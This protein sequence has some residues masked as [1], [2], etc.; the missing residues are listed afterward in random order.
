MISFNKIRDKIRD[1]IS[2]LKARLSKFTL[3]LLLA[4]SFTASST[5]TGSTIFNGLWKI[6][7]GLL[8]SITTSLGNLFGQIF[9]GFGQSI[10]S[11]FQSFGFSMAGYGV[12]APVMFVVGL[13]VAMLVGYLMLDFIDG[14]KDVTE[15][16]EAI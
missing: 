6:I 16:E 3:A 10:V 5:P 2:A 13:G 1:R 14:E 9:S 11:M 12:W 15:A 4:G 8:H 7:Y